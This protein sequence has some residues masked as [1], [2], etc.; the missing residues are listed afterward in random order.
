MGS[1][2]HHLSTVV[3]LPRQGRML[4]YATS[5]TCDFID[6]AAEMPWGVSDR[7]ITPWRGCYVAIQAE[8]SDLFVV[9]AKTT[10]MDILATGV[11]TADNDPEENVGMMIPAGQTIHTWIEEGAWKFLAFVTRTGETG[12]IRLWPSSRRELFGLDG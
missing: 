2:T 9:L 1:R 6:L 8:E 7:P 5:S 3:Q 12:Y 4:A 10:D 11:S